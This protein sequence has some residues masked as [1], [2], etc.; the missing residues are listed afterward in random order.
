M[1]AA[2][3]KLN[4]FIHEEKAFFASLDTQICWDSERWE[5][6][7]WLFHRGKA[8]HLIFTYPRQAYMKLPAGFCAPDSE[9]LSPI[10]ADFTKAIAVYIY[11]TKAAGYMAIRNYVNECRRLYVILRRRNEDSPACFT[12][13][14]FEEAVKIL[15]EI[16]YK[17]IYDATAN[18][19]VIA[20]VLDKK[21]ITP[22]PIDF[23]NSFTPFRSKHSYKAIA[24]ITEDD[25]RINDEKLPS[26]DAMKAY[27]VCTNNPINDD[28]EI[29]LRTIDLLI[30]MGQ[31]GNEVTLIPYDCWV[32][33]PV[34]GRHGEV[35]TDAN[36]AEIKEV[37]IRYY[38]E[39]NFQ[40]RVHW[41]AEQDI[42]LALRAVSRL[43]ELTKEVREVAKWQEANAGRLWRFSSD[44]AI[45]DNDLIK[46]LGFEH[47]YN[48]FLYLTRNN[49][50]PVFTNHAK[51]N[52]LPRNRTCAAH[53]YKAGDIESL[54]LPKMSDHIALKENIAGKWKVILKTS[55]VL[56]IRFDGSFRFKR[57][58]NVFKIFPGRTELPEI[59][60]A[61]GAISKLESIFDR[62]NLKEA[63]GSKIVLTS[64]QPRH[65][66]NTL[67]ELAG[68]SNVQQALAMGRQKL[69]QNKTYQHV[70]LSEQTH[71]HKEFLSFNSPMEKITF[72]HDGIRN[73]K[74]LGDLTDTYN[75]LKEDKGVSTAESFLKTHA[76]ALH[77]TP[78]GGCTHDF[79]QTPCLKH[80]QCWNGCSNLH[81]TNTPGE[82]EKLQRL[83]E[84][85]Q[86]ALKKLETK[87]SGEYGADVWVQDLR[88]KVKNLEMALTM[89]VESDPIAVF[90]DG[91]PVTLPL[92]KRKRSSI[93]DE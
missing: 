39:K 72:L 54:L 10:F 30:A 84:N 32:E 5:I 88:T 51:R 24:E 23:K 52:P 34:K 1:Q 82:T 69:T 50:V 35:I 25:K 81:R 45:E 62:R 37:G 49:I 80:L 36:G 67:Y 71:L 92:S 18:L 12:R 60:A 26:Y 28:E 63:D 17:N 68:M 87:S 22:Y 20:S 33:R 75:F 16:E 86:E 66:R 85:S 7:N 2:V 58:A 93:K 29:L 3:E 41:L 19:Q 46:L 61:L 6:Q 91:K 27:A 38:A 21:K 53:F 89:E 57:I 40:S 79:S 78:F 44:E 4:E 59:N 48:L 14:H 9:C 55:D 42:P 83:L 11:R 31:R 13:W 74:I 70:T 43:K 64:H 56:S 47:T 76:Q 73:S 8:A 77:I 90:P 65:W 15:E